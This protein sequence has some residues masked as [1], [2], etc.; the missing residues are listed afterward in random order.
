MP[1]K[2]AIVTVL[3]EADGAMHYQEIAEEI[4]ARGLRESLGATPRDTVGSVVSANIKHMGEASLFVRAGRAHYMLRSPGDECPNDADDEDTE[5]SEGGSEPDAD[6]ST[7]G[8]IQAF[9]MFWRRDAVFWKSKATLLGQQTLNST[10]VNFSDQVGVY[11]LHDGRYTVYVGRSS[12]RPLGQRMF[13]HRTDRLGGRWDRFSWFGLKMVGS[14][15]NL[16]FPTSV[17]SPEDWVR[18]MEALLI[19]AMEPPQNRRRG[20]DIAGVEYL[21]VRDPVLHKRSTQILLAEL[22]AKIME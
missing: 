10:P 3:R 2:K 20:D 9:G 22:Q 8:M 5:E 1:W 7:R 12:E 4:A 21:Q 6:L 19:E 15:G 13:E 17:P 16:E 18:T 14:E 11:L